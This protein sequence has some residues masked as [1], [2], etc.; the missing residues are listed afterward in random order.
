MLTILGRLQGLQETDA[1]I[2]WP[3]WLR[4]TFLRAIDPAEFERIDAQLFRQ[5]V[6]HRLCSERCIGRTWCPV[7]AALGFV[8]HHVKAIDLE[9]V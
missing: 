5:L 9:V 1:P 2:Y 4:R 6:D 7:G 8:Q 3:G